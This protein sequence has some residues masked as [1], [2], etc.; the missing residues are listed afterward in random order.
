MCDHGRGLDGRTV[1]RGRRAAGTGGNRRAAGQNR[2]L[3]R[4]RGVAYEARGY[5]QGWA[6][7]WADK[8]TSRRPNRFSQKL[9]L[10]LASTTVNKIKLSQIMTGS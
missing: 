9:T 6:N 8:R 10:F 5:K 7:E 3:G 2:R 1:V 4:R